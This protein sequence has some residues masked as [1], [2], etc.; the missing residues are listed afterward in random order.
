LQEEEVAMTLV[1]QQSVARRARIRPVPPRP[2]NTPIVDAKKW[3]GPHADEMAR[4]YAMILL[5]L[6]A[7]SR[8]RRSRVVQVMASQGSEG[9][10]SIALGL[11]VAAATIGRA[12]TLICDARTPVLPDAGRPSLNDVVAG[13]ANLTE[14]VARD[15]EIGLEFCTL[16][17]SEAGQA[18]SLNER[19]LVPLFSDL[20]LL[21]DLVIVDAPPAHES[22]VGLNLARR[23]DGIVLVVEAERTRARMVAAT[24]KLLQASG[25]KILGVVLNR[26]RRS[27][28]LFGGF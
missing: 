11:A 7:R 8:R 28:A 1:S 10:S 23:A 24:Q 3:L 12:R 4:L 25:G 14:V 18:T 13:A 16:G 21:F 2:A 19:A 6:P 20:R 22:F 26:R 27:K 15:P 9:V 5:A 17:A